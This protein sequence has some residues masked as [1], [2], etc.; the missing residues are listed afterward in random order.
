MIGIFI[1]ISVILF[2]FLFF[3]RKKDSFSI[4]LDKEEQKIKKEIQKKNIDEKIKDLNKFFIFIVFFFFVSCS[5]TKTIILPE[6]PELPI[7]EF[8]K[9]NNMACL[10]EQEVDKL[11]IWLEK[12]KV[13]RE[14][15]LKTIKEI[16]K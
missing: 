13:Y 16:E 6:P 11:L 1:F 15:L 14:K 10:K 8:V 4:S 9:H 3:T 5:S 7:L 2:I 12:Q